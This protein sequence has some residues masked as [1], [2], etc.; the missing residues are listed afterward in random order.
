MEGTLVYQKKK[1]R[2]LEL[3]SPYLQRKRREGKTSLTWKGGPLSGNRGGRRSPQGGL[4]H[5]K[6]KGLWPSGNEAARQTKKTRGGDSESTTSE[7]ELRG[8][9]RNRCGLQRVGVRTAGA[10]GDLVGEGKGHRYG[11]GSVVRVDSLSAGGTLD[12]RGKLDKKFIFKGHLRVGAQG[13]KEFDQR[14][15]EGGKGRDRRDCA[16]DEVFYGGV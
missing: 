6:G 9:L 1:E 12:I 14:Q 8:D 10:C 15:C 16:Y 13:K 4:R 5:R 11:E 3:Q 7:E 2:I